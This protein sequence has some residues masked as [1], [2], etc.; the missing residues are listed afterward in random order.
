MIRRL[1][2]DEGLRA[3]APGWVLA[4]IGVALGFVVAYVGADK[5]TPGALPLQVDQGLFA[6]DAAFYRDIAD[7]GYQGVAEEG[8]RFFPLLPLLA[9]AL[10]VPLLGHVGLALLVLVQVA[11]IAAGVLLYRLAVQETGD[12]ATGVR[13]AWFLA[14]LPP[15]T[16]LVLGYA[17]GLLLCFAIGF[18]LCIRRERWWLAAVLGVLAGLSR[19]VGMT[20]ALP[21]LIEALRLGRTLPWRAWAG[22]VAAIV[23]P[24]LGGGLFLAWAQRVHGDWQ[25]PLT[26]QNSAELRGGWANPLSTIWGAVDAITSQEWRE[27]LHVPWIAVFA[28][29]LVIAFRT[30]P[31]SYG[32]WSAV[33]LL[34]ALTGN[35][36]G[37]FERYGH[38]AFPL[39]LALA[40]ATRAPVVERAALVACGAAFSAFAALLFL[41][42]FV[43]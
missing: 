21:A 29:L 1:L 22:R 2:R 11:A 41:G 4:R 19:P 16:V 35:T 27:A 10:G 33:L 23:G 15:A 34:S 43:P 17:E 9:R 7:Y 39:I 13:A 40:I 8:L 3:A 25:L 5:L 24:V 28:V 12:R 18:F 30:L 14:V 37:S 32:A 26:L 38:A 6:W 42:A 31:A 20:L 36:L